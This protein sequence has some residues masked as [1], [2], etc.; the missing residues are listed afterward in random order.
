ME[1]ENSEG[2]EYGERR[3]RKR[4]KEYSKLEPDRARDQLVERANEFFGDVPPADD[5]TLVVGRFS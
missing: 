5:I 4:I 1:G 2:E 3:F